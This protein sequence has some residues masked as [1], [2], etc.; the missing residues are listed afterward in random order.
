[1]AYRNTQFRP[2]KLARALTLA[3]LATLLGVA[4]A[5]QAQQADEPTPTQVQEDEIEVIT[6]TGGFRSSLASAL[7][8]KRFA[9]G[10]TDTIKA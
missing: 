5:L 7:N 3:G 1:M 6:V 4:P 8:Q 2:S 10:A 9:T